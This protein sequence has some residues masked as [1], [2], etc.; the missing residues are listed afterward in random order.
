MS[1]Q[2]ILTKA[3]EVQTSKRQEKKVAEH[4]KGGVSTDKRLPQGLCTS[5]MHAQTCMYLKKQELPVFHCEEF[6]IA[7]VSGHKYREATLQ[8]TPS[9][10]QTRYRGLCSNCENRETCIYADTEGGVWHCEM[11][12]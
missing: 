11:Y 7:P 10:R 1:P 5:C 4:P 9:E 12:I 3:V 8:S 2:T 6:E